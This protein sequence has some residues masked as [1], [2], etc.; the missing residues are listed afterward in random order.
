MDMA[1]HPSVAA[2]EARALSVGQRTRWADLATQAAEA[3]AFYAPAMLGA[4]LDH[5]ALP[6]TVRLIE[7]M[8]GDQLIGLL[9]VATTARHGRL[10]IA[11]TANWM[12]PHNFFGAPLIREGYE[13]A[14]WVA[15]LEQL[16]QASWAPHFLHLRGLDAAGANAVALE[17]V[18]THQGRARREIHRYD[19]ALL[20]SNLSADAYWETQVRAKKRKEIRRLQKRLAEIG[21]VTEQLLTDRNDLT[22]WCDEFL[23]LEQSGW[24]GREGTALACTPTHAA[25]FR[26]ACAAGFDMGQL[27]FLRVDLDGRAIAMLV[28]FRH[29]DG[30]FSFKI[31]FDEE[32]GR[33]SPGVLIEIVNLQAV[34]GEPAIGWMDSCAASDHPMIDSLWAERR[35]IV[36]YRVALKGAG[37][38]RLRRVAAFAAVDGVEWLVRRIRGQR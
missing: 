14:A 31:A 22:R 10:P 11:C 13:H 2:D 12:H 3:N 26:A 21:T 15:F 38:A 9:P 17:A 23:A 6:G 34:L 30:A 8:D 33:F 4:A 20:R 37:G 28:N 5:L 36:Q 24:K 35:S 19:R 27:H 18:C 16:D 25:F 7:A 29:L 32:M 1:S